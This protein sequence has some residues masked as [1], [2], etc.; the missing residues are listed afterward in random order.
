MVQFIR[1]PNGHRMARGLHEVVA[2]HQVLRTPIGTSL[3]LFLSSIRPGRV[4]CAEQAPAPNTNL[5]RTHDLTR[6][7]LFPYPNTIAGT[8]DRLTLTI[9]EV[10]IGASRTEPIEKPLPAL[11]CVNSGIISEVHVETTPERHDYY[12]ERLGNVTFHAKPYVPI[13]R[14]AENRERL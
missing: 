13:A 1:T 14:Y 8:G 3:D 12:A 6:E 4:F 9:R 11:Y 2:V 10:L 5:Y 7:T